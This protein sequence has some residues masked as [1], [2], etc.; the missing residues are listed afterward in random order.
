MTTPDFPIGPAASPPSSESCVPP[1]LPPAPI[2]VLFAPWIAQWRL[3]Q[4]DEGPH[5]RERR[6]NLR[7]VFWTFAWQ[8][9]QAGASC[10]EAIRQAR[11]RCHTA[12]RP[13]PPEPDSPYLPG[14]RSLPWNVCR[15]STTHYPRSRGGARRQGPVVRPRRPGGRRLL[16]PPRRTLP[17]IKRCFRS[18][19]CRNPA[20]AFPLSGWSRC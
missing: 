19:R 3:A 7:L 9:A 13:L 6:W 11:A 12:G 20:A 14:A 18:S 2:R 8:V 1:P 10:R 16:D 5:S 17:P 4:Q 15:K